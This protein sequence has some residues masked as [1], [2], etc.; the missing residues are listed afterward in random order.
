MEDTISSKTDKNLELEKLERQ[1]KTIKDPA[2]LEVFRDFVEAVRC[3]D[4]ILLQ[5]TTNSAFQTFRLMAHDLVRICEEHSAD[6]QREL[7]DV[8]SKGEGVVLDDE[9]MKWHLCHIDHQIEMM[10]KVRDDVIALIEKFGYAVENRQGLERAIN[11]LQQFKENLLKNLPD[12]ERPPAPLNRQNFEEVKNAIAR[13]D[14]LM[15]RKD[16]VHPKKT[17]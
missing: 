12:L 4:E 14:K 15:T 7:E 9:S 16:L 3:D 8:S 2:L 1:G 10:T 17:G 5:S 6:T 11:E 13:G